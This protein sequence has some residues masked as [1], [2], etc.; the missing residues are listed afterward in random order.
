MKKSM[1]KLVSLG[2]ALGMVCSLGLSV[3]AAGKNDSG[4]G[5]WRSWSTW[6]NWNESDNYASV[7]STF[8]S[9]PSSYFMPE[10]S[11]T[12]EEMAPGFYMEKSYFPTTV[13]GVYAVSSVPV[14]VRTPA[15]E[16]LKKYGV[17]EGNSLIARFYD[18]P[19]QSVNAKA[20]LDAKA[21]ELGGTVVG[22]FDASLAE[23]NSSGDSL[24]ELPETS[25]TFT[26]FIG[27]GTNDPTKKLACIRVREGGVVDV[28]EDTY[29]DTRTLT[30]ETT[31]NQASYAAV[32]LDAATVV[33]AAV[34]PAAE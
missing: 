21:A 1:K 2:L 3:S 33:P 34:A 14:A 7:P 26:L 22:Y 27:C 12:N 31:P 11:D 5:D 20:M 16:L 23:V 32:V 15:Y 6:G 30:V 29:P 25:E 28:L 9:D 17:R 24:T 19:E 10:R 18:L 4:W 8:T 13:P